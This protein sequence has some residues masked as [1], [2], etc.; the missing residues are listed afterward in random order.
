MSDIDKIS[1]IISSLNKITEGKAVR[2]VLAASV[3][4]RLPLGCG[5]AASGPPWQRH[6]RARGRG[7]CPR[8]PSTPP[9]VASG[10]SS[11][12]PSC[13]A[14]PAPARAALRRPS[15]C[16]GALRS[17]RPPRARCACTPR[18]RCVCRQVAP[19][20]SRRRP[21]EDTGAKSALEFLSANFQ[22]AW[23]PFS[24]SKLRVLYSYHS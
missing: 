13:G 2:A 1:E 3:A 4:A 15:P 16:S 20:C 19:G 9:R 8:S 5:G 18:A 14:S 24:V 6:T 17:V 10:G 21:P 23:Q 11:P 22:R 7:A 12:P